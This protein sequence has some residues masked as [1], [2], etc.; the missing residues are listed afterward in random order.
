MRISVFG[1]G[2]VGAV[3]AACLADAGHRVIGVDTNGIKADLINAGQSPVLEPG[4]SK[5]I[6]EQ[7]NWGR[8]IATTDA[9]L[10]VSESDLALIC[11]GTPSRPNGDIDLGAMERVSEQIGAALRAKQQFFV[12]VVRSS[13]LPGTIGRVTGALED[14][15]GKTAG[16][17][18]G[19]CCNPEF[20]R[21]GSAI[22]DFRNPAKTVVGAS[23]PRTREAMRLLYASTTA[24]LFETDIAVAALVKYSDNAWHGLKVG[25]A[26]EIGTLCRALGLDSHRVMEIFCADTRLNLSPKYLQPGFAFGGSCL[27]KDLRALTYSARKH[28]LELPILDAVLVSNRRHLERGLRLIVD[29]QKRRIGVL[30]LSFKAGTDDL[31]ESPI[32]EVVE[33]LIGKGYDIRIFDPSVRAASLVGANRTYIL[34]RIPHLSRL[35]VATADELIEHAELVVIGNADHAHRQVLERMRDDQF[36][37]DFVRLFDPPHS[38]ERYHGICW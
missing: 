38:G 33:H 22:E 28:D 13:V 23:D 15:S 12:V 27:P 9:A 14:A 10:A 35:L 24:P 26:N 29:Q 8:L 3:S 20:L 25:F 11:V 37:V 19:I 18:F 1:L 34:D 7:R 4:L 30:G 5:L 16:H 17:D 2:Y 32:V 6:A 31:R 21:E 36:V